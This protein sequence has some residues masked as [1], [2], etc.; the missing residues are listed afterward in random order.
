MEHNVRNYRDVNIVLNK[1]YHN[2]RIMP[3]DW[4]K[5]LGW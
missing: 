3:D 4:A 5:K 1:Y 2:P